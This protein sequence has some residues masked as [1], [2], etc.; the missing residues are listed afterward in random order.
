M[1]VCVCVC[2]CLDECSSG[3]RNSWFSI[4]GYCLGPVASLPRP[5]DRQ[6]FEMFARSQCALLFSPLS[7]RHSHLR[8]RCF[9]KSPLG[10]R[11]LYYAMTHLLVAHAF[12]TTRTQITLRGCLADCVLMSTSYHKKKAPMRIGAFLQSTDIPRICLE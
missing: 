5:F 9:P 7:D 12:V 8:V 11:A 2:V 10:R 1:C 6:Q 4:S 3:K